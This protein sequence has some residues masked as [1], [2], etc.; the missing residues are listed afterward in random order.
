MC[1]SKSYIIYTDINS[2]TPITEQKQLFISLGIFRLKL[3][4][5]TVMFILREHRICLKNKHMFINVL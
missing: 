2:K 3:S 5:T 4:Y 1:L